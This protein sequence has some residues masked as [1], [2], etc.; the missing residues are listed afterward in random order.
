MP[1]TRSID[2]PPGAWWE[3]CK[4]VARREL[5]DDCVHCGF[6]L[7]HCPTYQSW[8][9]EMDSPRGRIDLMKGLRSG[10]VSLTGEVVGYFDRCLGCLACVTACPSGVQYGTLIEET[11]ARVEAAHR[12][13]LGDR[14]FRGLVFWLFPHPARL[15][16]MLLPLWLYV[17]S[18]LQRL[19]RMSGLL[20]L[21]PERLR[22]LEAML[23][24]V[25]WAHLRATQP[26]SVPAQGQKRAT[27]G[28]VAGCVQRV[29][30]PSVNAATVRVLAAEGC[31]V[32]IPVQGCCG[33]L[34]LHTGR[35]TEG[36]AMARAL[37]ARFEHSGVDTVIINSAGCGS[38]LKDY[39]HLLSG[40]LAWAQRARAFSAKVRDVHE[41]L[42]ALGPRSVRH[43][44]RARVAYHDACHLAHG[45]GI[46]AQPRE[47]LRAIPGVELLEVP[48][49]DTCCGS[50]GTYNLMEP[51]SAAEIGKRKVANVLRTGCHLLASANPGCT[52][53]IQKLVRDQGGRLAAAHP[54]EI[55]DASLRGAGLNPGVPNASAQS[56][57]QT[58][59]SVAGVQGMAQRPPSAPADATHS[60]Q[61]PASA[62][63]TS[64]L[65]RQVDKGWVPLIC[66]P[67]T[68]A[69]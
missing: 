53:Q 25:R 10:K 43:P 15:R 2:S 56:R 13:G 54:I 66:V 14:A 11:R 57:A 39:G 46:R 33:S 1:S 6:C 60:M 28:L 19:V 55:L 9:E 47:L 26:A 16:A 51:A 59:P 24:E 41:F 12:R 61:V 5:L 22:Q 18:G 48:D 49:G 62:S 42:A 65:T 30:F 34:S 7:P 38:V 8:G 69:V 27:V 37:I 67:P 21:V 23:P 32:R 36:L 68:T 44:V 29:F 40:D 58:P 20:R 17:V 52:L 50:A 4:A 63:G 3:G 31:E 64:S 35:A 45:Q